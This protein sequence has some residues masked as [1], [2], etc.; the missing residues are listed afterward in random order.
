MSETHCIEVTGQQLFEEHADEFK[1]LGE[2]VY[3]VPSQ[4]GHAG[5]EVTLK[6]NET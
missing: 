2:G 1:Y 5:Y 3:L 6:P 4:N